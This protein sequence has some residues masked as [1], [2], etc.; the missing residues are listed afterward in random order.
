VHIHTKN[1]VEQVQLD[2]EVGEWFVSFITELKSTEKP[3]TYAQ[4]KTHFESHLPDDI[5]TFIYSKPANQLKQ[6]G[7]LVV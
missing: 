6:L 5:E 2:K 4:L 1:A 7:L 3:F